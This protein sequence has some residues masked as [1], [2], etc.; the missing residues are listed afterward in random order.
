MTVVC[1]NESESIWS[2][3]LGSSSYIL[4]CCWNCWALSGLGQA[5]RPFYAGGDTLK[6]QSWMDL[7]LDANK[8]RFHFAVR[9]RTC[10]SVYVCVCTHVRVCVHLHTCACMS[11]LQAAF[12]PFLSWLLDRQS[13]RHK[14]RQAFRQT[15]RQ[16]GRQTERQTDRQTHRQTDRQTDRPKDRQTNRPTD[17]Q[18]RRQSATQ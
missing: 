13:D 17:R 3:Y 5:K 9:H 14:D 12:P 15:Q 7:P 16:T 10:M 11:I 18:T 8:R 6:S 1:L 4:L 2:I